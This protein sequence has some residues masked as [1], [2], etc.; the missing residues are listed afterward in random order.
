MWR[1]LLHDFHFHFVDENILPAVQPPRQDFGAIAASCCIYY[2]GTKLQ[3][4][5]PWLF[6]RDYC[7]WIGMVRKLAQI[8]CLAQE[9]AKG[10][11]GNKDIIECKLLRREGDTARRRGN[12][13]ERSPPSSWCWHH[14]DRLIHPSLPVDDCCVNTPSNAIFHS[15]SYITAEFFFSL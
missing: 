2:M 13:E 6:V 12:W 15:L 11:M 7:D 10:M 4:F 9:T 1:C 14:P 3:L 8:A 5:A